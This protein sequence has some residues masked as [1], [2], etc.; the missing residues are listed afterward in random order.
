[1]QSA[2][3]PAQKKQPVRKNQGKIGEILIKFD[4]DMFEDQ[5]VD[6][7]ETKEGE[8]AI[9]AALGQE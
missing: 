9:R 7:L 5:V 4:N 1:M 8:F 3:A 6:V 2:Q